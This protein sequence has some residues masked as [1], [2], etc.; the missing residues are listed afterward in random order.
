MYDATM[1]NDFLSPVT[2]KTYS[3]NGSYS[4]CSA[5]IDDTFKNFY[6]AVTDYSSIDGILQMKYT[7]SGN[8]Y[9]NIINY[10][11]YPNF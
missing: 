11:A 4:V 7:D 1:N 3:Y 8:Y 10:S 6:I 2:L 5:Y 9:T